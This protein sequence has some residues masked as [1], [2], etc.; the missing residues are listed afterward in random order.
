MKVNSFFNQGLVLIFLLLEINTGSIPV[1]ETILNRGY[2]TQR[3]RRVDSNSLLIMTT[4]QK[5]KDDFEFAYCELLSQ[6]T[7]TKKAQKRF[8]ES[9][10]IYH[11]HHFFR[12]MPELACN[13]K[14][15]KDFLS[16]S[17]S[18]EWL[19]KSLQECQHPIMMMVFDYFIN[20][21]PSEEEK[22]L[23]KKYCGKFLAAF[24]EAAERL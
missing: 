7:L 18:C 16:L 1:G 14:T 10:E 4:G 15:V 11:Y 24:P 6:Y 22:A 12:D 23:F 5:Y 13:E 19:R 2:A 21:S 17:P 3:L 20:L 9:V 8:L